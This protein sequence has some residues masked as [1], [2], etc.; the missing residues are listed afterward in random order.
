MSVDEGRQLV[1]LPTSSPSPDFYGG[2]RPGANRNANSV[3]AL[4]A[5][6][7]TLAWAFQ[8][9]KH[10]VWDYDVSAQPTLA[11][12][13]VDG[14]PHD[15][16][17]QATKQ[18]FVFVLDRDT[19]R[20]VFPVEERAVP[21]GG[22]PGEHLSPTQTFPVDLPALVPLAL[23]PDDAF[24]FTFFDR[25]ACRDR[26]AALRNDGLYTPPSVQGSLVFPFTGG[27]V[28]WGGV[29][30]DPGGIVYVNTSRA[31]HA[32]RLVPRADYAATR[33][34]NDDKEVSPQAGTR[35]G[36]LRELV[37]SPF[38]APCN[39]PPWGTLAALDLGSRR[40]LWQAP[41]GTTE[42]LLPLGVALRTGTP[43][44]GGPAA[45]RRS[46]WA[47][48]SCRRPPSRS[49]SCA[50]SGHADA[51]ARRRSSRRR[52]AVRPVRTAACARRRL[53]GPKRAPYNRPL[54]R[55]PP[56]CKS[57]HP[58]S[59]PTTYAASSARRSMRRSPNTSDAPSAAPRSA[60]A[61]VPWRSAAT[62]AFRA[63]SSSPP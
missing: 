14:R 44:F 17:V 13:A 32:V 52:H 38:G 6:D 4:H 31:V 34:H 62:A 20:P 5:A 45:T 24:G 39:K 19:G 50:S 60:P 56:P 47:H 36:M 7:G 43:N 12:L 26:I 40:I 54:F 9:V 59:R 16:V 28:N 22:A 33:A 46:R 30:I 63:R 29:A 23:R 53:P 55:K 1:F 35:F 57:P 27:G 18:G 37:V 3:V 2:L 25:G 51:I 48:S 11:T 61:S 58:I 15:V 49:G 21:Q 42:E 8:V 41:L 10:D